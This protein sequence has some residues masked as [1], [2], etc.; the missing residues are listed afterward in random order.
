MPMCWK[1][2]CAKRHEDDLKNFPGDEMIPRNIFTFERMPLMLA[3]P[4][5]KFS[6]NW[7][8]GSQINSG[9]FELTSDTGL[10]KPSYKLV[11]FITN[12][13]NTGRGAT[14]LNSSQDRSSARVTA[15]LPAGTPPSETVMGFLTSYLP[16]LFAIL[17]I[18]AS[19]NGGL[20]RFSFTELPYVKSSSRSIPSTWRALP[21]ID[22]I[23]LSRAP[24]WTID[25]SS[26][27][28]TPV[29]VTFSD[30]Q[31][32]TSLGV[33]ATRPP[34]TATRYWHNVTG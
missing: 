10:A 23:V 22:A 13:G 19:L 18:S 12:H 34:F 30:S 27:S 5:R 15:G 20:K 16:M 25:W 32:A 11:P 17:R 28:A 21:R 14:S 6:I 26:S 24:S 2:S 31:N 4:C 9:S 7:A 29:L 1:Y 8:A 3:L 33:G